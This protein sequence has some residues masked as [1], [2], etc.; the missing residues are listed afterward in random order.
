VSV[1]VHLDTDLGTDPDDVCAL[2]ML[3]GWRGVEVVGVTTCAD[4]GG[5]RAA[6]VE[7]C[8]RLLGRSDVRV[9]VGAPASLSHPDV[10]D[11]VV[12]TRYWPA[13]VSPRASLPGPSP[14]DAG[15]V[16]AASVEAGAVLVAIG[17]YTNLAE[18]ERQQP[19]VLADARVVAMGGWLDPPDAGLPAWG[20][21][22]DYNVQWDV[23]AAREVFAAAGDL[24]LSTLP[25]SL[26]VPLRRRDL[27][28]LRDMGPI[29]RLIARQ[30]EAHAEDSGKRALGPAHALLPDDL[31]NFH[32]DPLTCAVAVGWPGAVVERRRLSIAMEGP[33]LR[34]VDD[35][36]GRPVHV[37]TDVDPRTFTKV[38]LAADARACARG[39]R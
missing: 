36:D 38:W 2:A 19:G 20:P 21:D 29:G 7:H 1:L 25:V 12:D 16:L 4:R 9:A 34:M 6:Y 33:V 13:E 3:L 8:L 35:E 17:P 32:Y 23:Q 24:T 11:P 5:M 22:R 14:T 27:A 39:Q 18:L 31:L 30:S 10:A 28:A 26:K 37:V 15:A